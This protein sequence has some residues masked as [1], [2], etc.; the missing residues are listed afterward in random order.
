MDYRKLLE[1][2]AGAVVI[3]ALTPTQQ[4]KAFKIAKHV[5]KRS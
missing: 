5:S 4:R 3:L 2:V 1:K